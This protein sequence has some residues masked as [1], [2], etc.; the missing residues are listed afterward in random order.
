MFH[1]LIIM[2]LNLVSYLQDTVVINPGTNQK[3]SVLMRLSNRIRTLEQNLSLSSA[4]LENL[5]RR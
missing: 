2:A 5:S 1:C 4:Y 3:E